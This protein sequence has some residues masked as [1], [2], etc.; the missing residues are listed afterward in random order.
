MLMVTALLQVLVAIATA[1]LAIMG[2]QFVTEGSGLHPLLCIVTILFMTIGLIAF[3]N[4]PY[5]KAHPL[6]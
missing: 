1:M 4:L 2:Y 3:N 5:S 6:G